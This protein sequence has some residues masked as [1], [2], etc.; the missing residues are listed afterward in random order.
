MKKILFHKLLRPQVISGEKTKTR[1]LM[2]PQPDIPT[3]GDVLE[4]L[5]F[6]GRVIPPEFQKPRYKVGE[7]VYI[8]EPY[9][10]VDNKVYYEENYPAGAK[11][12]NKLFMPE[13]YARYFIK[14][15]GVRAERLQDISDEDCIK[16]GIMESNQKGVFFSEVVQYGGAR[17]GICKPFN[18]PQAAFAAL[19]DKINGKG[20]WAGNPFVWV[21]DFKIIN[22]KQ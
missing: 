11:L 2:N 22:N 4:D 8:A 3:L 5:H 21:Y 10:V 1:R 12:K 18:T 14:I 9:V 15:T 20:T 17:A 13:K 6:L 16:E 19:I 7:V